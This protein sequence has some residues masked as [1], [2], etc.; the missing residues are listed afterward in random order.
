MNLRNID[1]NLLVVLDALLEERHVSRAANR[2]GLSQPAASNALDR[3]RHRFGDPLL[4][5]RGRQMQLT[6]RAEALR[7]PLRRVLQDLG[8]VVK[9][10]APPDIAD[11]RQTVRLALA[12]LVA[13]MV[14]PPLYGALSTTAPGVALAVLPWSSGQSV[15]ERLERDELDLGVMPPV[16]TPVP[17]KRERLLRVDYL[18]AMRRDHPAAADFGLKAWLAYPHL[19]VSTNGAQQGMLDPILAAR[20]LRR[21]VKMTVS[22]FLMVPRILAETDL[23][24][25]LPASYFC[26]AG[27]HPELVTFPPPIPLPGTDIHLAWHPRRDNDVAVQ[28][29]GSLL[30]RAV[31]GFEKMTC[32]LEYPSVAT[33][34]GREEA[35]NAEKPVQQGPRHRRAA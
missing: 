25:L 13:E 22:G 16:D 12:D 21:H 34:D 27:R 32:F 8:A 20:G 11:L 7:E 10:P 2:L 29:V 14:L 5:R 15:A 33:R 19:L 18:V 6:S 31:R 3:L 26:Q 4:E 1:L 30:R 35:G 9:G 17:L 23:I 28:A 24:T